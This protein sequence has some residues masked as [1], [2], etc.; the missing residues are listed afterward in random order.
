MDYKSVLISEIEKSAKYNLNTYPFNYLGS[1]NDL[2][3]YNFNEPALDDVLIRSQKAYESNRQ[4]SSF[5]RSEILLEAARL[6]RIHKKEMSAIISY[7]AKKPIKFAEQEVE[8]SIQTLK[9]SGIESSKLEGEYLNL[10]VAPNG[11]GREAFTKIES[12]GVVYAM[13]PFNFPLNLA[14]HKIGPAI[15]VGNSVIVKPSEKTPF[16]TYFLKY[17]LEESG[18]PKDLVQVVTGDGENITD[19]LLRYNEVKKVSFT[20]SVRVGKLI[21]NKV[22]LRK[23][24]LELGSTSPVFVSKN[25]TIKDLDDIAEQ[26]VIGAFS[27]NGQ[28]CISTQKVYIDDEI[29]ETLL[30]KIVTKTKSLKY[31]DLSNYET[32]YSDLIDQQAKNRILQW[33]TESKNDGAVVITGGN[34]FNG[35]IEPT[36]ITNTNDNMKI[37]SEEIF[38]PLVVVENIKSKSIIELLNNSQYGLNVGVFTSDLTEA[39]K[40]SNELDYGQVLINDVPTLRFDHM[41]YNGRRNSGYGT[42]GI[43][44]AIKE[45]SQMKMVS[46]KYE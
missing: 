43:K 3:I 28:V 19:T 15:A 12:L 26:I 40:L 22:G 35:A 18:L 32:D 17:L 46:L 16:S 1:L 29:Y 37:C 11:A 21:K 38:G 8:R 31:G 2:Y 14:I 24:T 6:L 4:L 41:P 45:M 33:I 36:V 30:E 34:S 7:E 25:N 42:E 39:L 20:G 44:Y 10:D 5:E 27:Y 9:L 23:L 13:T